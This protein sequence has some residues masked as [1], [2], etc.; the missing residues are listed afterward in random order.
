ME[1][2]RT[3]DLS[4]FFA[5]FPSLTSAQCEQ[6][7]EFAKLLLEWNERINLVS[8][9]DTERLVVHHIGHSLAPLLHIPFSPEVSVLDLGTGGG[10]PGIPLAIAYPQVQFHL[11]DSIAKKIRAVEDIVTRLHLPNVRVSR[12]RAEELV[13]KYDWVVTRGVAN[14]MQLWQWAQPLIKP[15]LPSGQGGLIAYKGFP[16]EEETN[17]PHASIKVIPLTGLHGDEFFDAKCLVHVNN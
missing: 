14:L 2:L 17:L 1:I 15:N 6:L 3:T 8:R 10:L 13:E 11:I 5:A 4:F 7:A 12:I 9:K 16:L